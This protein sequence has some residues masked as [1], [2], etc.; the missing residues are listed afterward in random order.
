LSAGQ[1]NDPFRWYFVVA[2]D[3][4]LFENQILRFVA[5]SSLVVMV[6]M[7]VMMIIMVIVVVIIIIVVVVVVI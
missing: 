4:G 3:L 7:V 2:R 6:I 5:L 1:F